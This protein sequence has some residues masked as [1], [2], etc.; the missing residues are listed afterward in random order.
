MPQQRRNS[1]IGHTL[2]ER[3]GGVGVAIPVTRNATRKAS[4]IRSVFDPFELFRF[5]DRV[6]NPQ[7]EK[8]DDALRLSALAGPLPCCFPGRAFVGLRPRLRARRNARG[9][10]GGHDRTDRN[11]NRFGKSVPCPD[12]VQKGRVR[13]GRKYTKE[14]LGKV[15]RKMRQNAR[16]YSVPGRQRG[17]YK[18]VVAGSIPAASTVFRSLCSPQ[19]S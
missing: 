10:H 11:A 17:P 7:K 18:R 2:G 5:L 14:S 4:F 16:I 9:L 12:D 6:V 8:E 3:V 15:S 19:P 1:R 13:G